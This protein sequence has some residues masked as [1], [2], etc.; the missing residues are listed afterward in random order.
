[1]VTAALPTFT[2][3]RQPF[4]WGNPLIYVLAMAVAAV[5]FAPVVYVILGGFRT[6]GQI[7]ANPAGLPHPWVW[8]TYASV[9]R[10]SAFWPELFNSTL[11][12]ATTTL[13]VV[14]LGG[15][16]ALVRARD[17]C[18]RRQPAPN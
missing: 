12:A 18:H 6:T 3:N 1:M 5:S 4:R 7:A 14:A 15:P 10:N 2:R 16:P 11:I 9:L 13:R 17:R 8:S